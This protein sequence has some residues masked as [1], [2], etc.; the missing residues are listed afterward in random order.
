M[1]I[2]GIQVT[3]AKAGPRTVEVHFYRVVLHSDHPEHVVTVNVHVVI[4]NLLN[5]AGRS[6][7]TGVYVESNKGERRLMKVPIRTNELALA[8]PHVRLERK[9]RNSARRSVG[10][11]PATTNVG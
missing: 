11:S 3:D 4:V 8:E 1:I 2:E 10:S 7:R 5:E 6:N 9:R